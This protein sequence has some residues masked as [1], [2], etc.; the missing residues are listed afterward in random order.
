VEPRNAPSNLVPFTA[1]KSH[2]RGSFPIGPLCGFAVYLGI[3]TAVC[4]IPNVGLFIV[5]V[6]TTLVVIA[7]IARTIRRD[8]RLNAEFAEAWWATQSTPSQR[9]SGSATDSSLSGR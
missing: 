2:D 6:T 3:G 4:S 5:A 7:L 9:T 1:T 8:N